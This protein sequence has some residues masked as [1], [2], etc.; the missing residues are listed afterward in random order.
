MID[1]DALLVKLVDLEGRHGSSG[2]RHLEQV[3]VA[4]TNLYMASS[5]CLNGTSVILMMQLP[6]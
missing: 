2:E 3:P 6:S 1:Y 4:S 5:H